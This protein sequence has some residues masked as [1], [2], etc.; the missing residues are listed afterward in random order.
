[1]N[2]IIRLFSAFLLPASMVS[3]GIDEMR[4]D[5]TKLENR[6][7]NLESYA[8]RMNASLEGLQAFIEGGK[9][10][11]K[12]TGPD[13]NGKYLLDLSDG[14][15]VELYQGTEGVVT[16]PEIRVGD[17][18]F[19]YINDVRQDDC[20]AVG[21]NAAVPE[22]RVNASGNWEVSTDGGNVWTDKLVDTDGDGVCDKEVK[23]VPD[24][25]EGAPVSSP[26]LD[27]R[28]EGD[29]FVVELQ[30]GSEYSLPIVVAPHRGC[31]CYWSMPFRTGFR[32]E[33]ENKGDTMTEIFAYKVLFHQQK[34]EKDILANPLL[35]GITFSGGEPF[36]QAKQLL[37]LAKFIKEKGLE[38]AS[39]TGFLFEELYNNKVPFARELLNYIDVLIDGKFVLAQRSLNLKF[40]GSKNQRTID[41]QASLKEG[42]A[43][44]STNE[45]WI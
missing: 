25:G 42:K 2:K 40:K 11:S 23:A 4:D 22:F 5:L 12:V 18:G 24:S 10:I 9:T 26:I 8:D 34:V 45:K 6:V 16:Y 44:L 28:M 36:I 33:V 43:V 19:W 31:N 39:Y 29:V 30:D 21:D 15:Q 37:P 7:E 1:M 35:T 41:V 13:E 32:I 20:K 3:C 14:T 38:L 27:A 17:D